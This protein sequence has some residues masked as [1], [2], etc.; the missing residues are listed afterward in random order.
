MLSQHGE[1]MCDTV[2]EPKPRG[3][4]CSTRRGSAKRI[5]SPQ[6][7]EVRQ[8][9]DPSPALDSADGLAEHRWYAVFCLPQNEKSVVRHL[10][11]RQV[12]A[13]LPT[14]EVVKVWKN[15]QRVRT[16]LP[17]FPTYLFVHINCRQRCRVLESPG[18]IHIVGNGRE[19]VPV[20]DSAIDLLRS[21]VE[22]RN[23]EPYRELVVGKKVR[24]KSGSM[25]GL[26][27]ILVRKGNG[28]R[29]VLALEMINQYAALEVD[30]EDL[31]HV[32]D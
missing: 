30:A 6:L 32:E 13:F 23:M 3:F 11:L 4:T 8:H 15:R 31:E 9:T 1:A 14:Y 21:G 24:I 17:L 29:F 16:E 12:E 7:Q 28:L 27:G 22:H 25:E 19:Y 18:V 10:A 2:L 5:M 26:Q 20:P